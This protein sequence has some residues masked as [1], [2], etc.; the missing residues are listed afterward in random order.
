MGAAPGVVRAIEH[1]GITVPDIEEASA[2][3][4]AAFGAEVLYDMKPDPGALQ[5]DSALDSE[6]TLGIR[7]GALW[8]SS[9]M[10]RLGDGPSIELFEYSDEEQAAPAIAS[11][12]GI[13]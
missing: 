4:E 9:R 2:F 1:V 6:A 7:P 13:Q 12:F 8:K 10:L 5:V 11:D 3:L